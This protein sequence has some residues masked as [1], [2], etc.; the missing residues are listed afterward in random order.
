[1]PAIELIALSRE[2]R[3]WFFALF[4]LLVAVA[5]LLLILPGASERLDHDRLFSDLSV[6]STLASVLPFLGVWTLMTWAMMLPSTL[7]T[8]TAV[9]RVAANRG[10]GAIAPLLFSFGYVA[11]WSAFGIFA[12]FSDYVV[13]ST[14]ARS[15]YL[16]NHEILITGAVI[17]IA[18]VYQ[19][20]P[21][22]D[23][24]L[25][26]CRSPLA[27]ILSRKRDGLA[28]LVLMG[29]DHG[30]FCVGC[31]WALMLLMFAFATSS[32][33]LMAALAI[34]FFVEKVVKNSDQVGHW[35]GIVAVSAGAVLLVR[36]FW[37]S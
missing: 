25:K 33:L 29:A 30:L 31:C 17:L 23:A 36:G 21:L 9:V 2:E 32:L 28:G 11:V 20:T 8:Q 26:S 1:L 22:K 14:V 18:G 19:F 35:S 34:Y 24:C 12:F 10:M 4:T 5:W 7:S 6:N 37:F 16:H 27:F 13:H 3:K 15:S